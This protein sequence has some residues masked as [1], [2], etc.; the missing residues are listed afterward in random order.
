MLYPTILFSFSNSVCHIVL[1]LDVF[2]PSSSGL[3]RTPSRSQGSP[4]GTGACA[5][6]DLSQV[7][8][9]KEEASEGYK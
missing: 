9:E 3:L 2:H 8:S 5:G 7:F 1:Q 4:P 6:G